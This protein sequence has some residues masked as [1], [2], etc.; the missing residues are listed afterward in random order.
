MIRLIYKICPKC[1]TK[2]L[3][4]EKCPNGCLDFAKKQNDKYYDKYS[5]KNADV[6]NN[7]QWE[8]TRLNCLMRYDSICVYSYYKHNKI[9]PAVL[10]HHIIEVAKDTS[11]KLIYDL[12]NLIPVSDEAHREIHHRYKTE[13]LEDV[14]KELKDYCTA[15]LFGGRG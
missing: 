14:Q 3:V 10:V 8:R 5:R 13:R 15:Y 9:V 12:N 6:Y 7:R 11:K 4:G 2:Y 1:R